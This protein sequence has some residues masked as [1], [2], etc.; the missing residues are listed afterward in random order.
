MASKKRD[1]NYVDQSLD[2]SYLKK[3]HKIEERLRNLYEKK[4]RLIKKIKDEPE[5]DGDS[6]AKDA[7]RKERKLT[8][9][10]GVALEKFYRS[11]TGNARQFLRGQLRDTIHDDAILLQVLT[12]FD[13]IDAETMNNEFALEEEAYWKGN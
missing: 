9:A 4:T 7:I 10:C 3:Q 12:R 1:R 5:S 6:R 13:A 2:D 11:R 8:H